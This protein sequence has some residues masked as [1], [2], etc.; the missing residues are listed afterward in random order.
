MHTNKIFWLKII[1]YV[2]SRE[3][4]PCLTNMHTPALQA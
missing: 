4:T 3:V 2:M 1:P